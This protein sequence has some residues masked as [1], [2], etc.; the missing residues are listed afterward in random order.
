MSQLTDSQQNSG[1]L[2]YGCLVF[3]DPCAH[4]SGWKAVE[5]GKGSRVTLDGTSELSTDIVWITNM[6]Y[7]ISRESGLDG[8]YRFLTRDYLREDLEKM[9]QRH[10][11]DKQDQRA[12]AE[13]GAK[14][15]SRTLRVSQ[16]LLDADSSEDFLPKFALKRGFREIIG[17]GRDPFYTTEMAKRIEEAISF[18]TN[19]EREQYIPAGED[20]IGYFRIPAREHCL[21]VMDVPLPFGD[22]R[23]I[24]RQ[25][26]PDPK[27]SREDVQKWLVQ[28]AGNRPGLFKITC[29]NFET[30]FNGLINYGNY[31]E[32]ATGLNSYKRQWV[33]SP[34]LA[35]LT[36]FSEITV[37]QAFVTDS[38]YQL[39]QQMKLVR[40]LSPVTDMSVTMGVFFEN[41]WTGICTR[42]S[43]RG[44]A[45]SPDKVP[46]NVF[47]PFLR[48][49][50]RIRL[51]DKALEFSEAGFDVAGYASGTLRV[52]IRDHD[53]ARVYDTCVK[54]RMIPPFLG[55][56]EKKLPPPNQRDPVEY[57]I[58]LYATSNYD[59][60]LFLN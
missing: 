46:I 54:T 36:A 28:V 43:S 59:L 22:F 45:P 12:V 13:F 44:T 2:R 20:I 56:D 26:L 38:I 47:T 49:M 4:N 14:I 6:G 29:R 16:K 21:A 51:F 18:N 40:Q 7:T 27:A 17:L 9:A 23:E 19:C 34:E 50:D 60:I 58:W 55:C 8:N 41:L 37:H 5:E 25:A 42:S 11:I 32:A 31:G 10:G 35:F 53:P 30:R 3:D 15:L 39:N 24:P 57:S 48:A 1:E 33:S 52:S